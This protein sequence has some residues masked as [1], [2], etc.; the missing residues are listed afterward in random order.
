[1]L[2]SITVLLL[3][4]YLSF[5]LRI[6]PKVAIFPVSSLSHIHT[7]VM[8]MPACLLKRHVYILMKSALYNGRGNR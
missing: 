8:D 2:I 7:L 1:M 4:Y 6:W 3:G 5:M